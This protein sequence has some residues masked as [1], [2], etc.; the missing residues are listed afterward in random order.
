MCLV[1]VCNV[2]DDSEKYTM[3]Y[4]IKPVTVTVHYTEGSPF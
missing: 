3:N 1:Y 4:Y 2:F